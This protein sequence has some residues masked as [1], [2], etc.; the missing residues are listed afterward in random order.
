MP[1]L[2]NQRYQEF[3]HSA[4]RD[5]FRG[6]PIRRFPWLLDE[7]SFSTLAGRLEWKIEIYCL[8]A[9]PS[10]FGQNMN[11]E[12][13]AK[14]KLTGESARGQAFSGSTSPRV[15]ALFGLQPLSIADQWERTIEC[16]MEDLSRHAS[17]LAK[18]MTSY[19]QEQWPVERIRTHLNSVLRQSSPGGFGTSRL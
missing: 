3:E 7:R 12:L 16:R 5:S 17:G 18:E 14:A 15:E 10:G 1:I 11:F 9:S 8:N 19:L 13:Q 2:K 4:P 6:E